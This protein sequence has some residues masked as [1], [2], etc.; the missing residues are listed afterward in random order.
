MPYETCQALRCGKIFQRDGVNTFCLEHRK[1]EHR[2]K[3]PLMSYGEKMCIDCRKTFE[4][5]GP[6]SVRCP[7]CQKEKRKKYDSE[8]QRRR[9]ERRRKLV[10]PSSPSQP[11][12]NEAKILRILIAAGAVTLE[13]VEAASRLISEIK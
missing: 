6:R 12:S 3:E 13:K 1:L 5:S 2:K 8:K 4:P 11:N 7:D 10:A 9:L